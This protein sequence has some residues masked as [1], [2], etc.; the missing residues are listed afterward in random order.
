MRPNRSMRAGSIRIAG[1]EFSF[2]GSRAA[3][4]RSRVA[5]SV[6]SPSFQDIVQVR[7]SVFHK[8]VQARELFL[9]IGDLLLQGDQPCVDARGLFSSAGS[10]R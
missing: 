8:T 10:E 7:H 4:A 1:A 2:A 3:F 6:V 5:F 9:S